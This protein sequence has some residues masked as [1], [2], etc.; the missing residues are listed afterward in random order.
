LHESARTH[1]ELMKPS[2]RYQSDK[3]EGKESGQALGGSSKNQI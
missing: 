3:D 2:T 1:A